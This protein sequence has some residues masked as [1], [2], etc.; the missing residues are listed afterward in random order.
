MRRT[1]PSTTGTAGRSS[2]PLSAKKPPGHDPPD[3]DLLNDARPETPNWSPLPVSAK[4]SS[5]ADGKQSLAKLSCDRNIRFTARDQIDAVAHHVVRL[6]QKVLQVLRQ[7]LAQRLARVDVGVRRSVRG[8]EFVGPSS[9]HLSPHVAW[10]RP[11]S[12]LCGR[13]SKPISFALRFNQ[14]SN[15]SMPI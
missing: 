8:L 1:R 14:P 11:T 6:A 10:S 2:A 4:N 13:T 5:G 12:F 7:G 15:E 9:D 3:P